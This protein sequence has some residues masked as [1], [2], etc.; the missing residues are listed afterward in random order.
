MTKTTKATRQPER[1]LVGHCPNCMRVVVIENHY[2]TWP[3]A[4]CQCGWFGW[5]GGTNGVK[6]G[7]LYERGVENDN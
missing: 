3:L 7:K 6:N 5:G 1:V 4:T 2:E